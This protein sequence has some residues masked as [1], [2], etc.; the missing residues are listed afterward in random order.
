ML[1]ILVVGL[2]ALGAWTQ[3]R[4]WLSAKGVTPQQLERWRQQGPVV[5]ADLRPPEEFN[6]GHVEG[7]VSVPWTRLR[8]Q[9]HSWSP[10]DRVV[11]VC[12]TGYRSLQAVRFLQMRQFRDVHWLKG[13]MLGWAGHCAAGLDQTNTR[14]HV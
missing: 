5:V 12:Q 8:Q 11:L 10:Q 4:P 1:G 13:G 7:A 2:L 14:A 6:R 9:H 3:L